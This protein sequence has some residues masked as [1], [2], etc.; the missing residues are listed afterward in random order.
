ME[1]IDIGEDGSGHC[2]QTKSSAEKNAP[3]VFVPAPPYSDSC[4]EVTPFG[5]EGSGAGLVRLNFD[6]VLF[7][8]RKSV[9]R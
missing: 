9:S 3:T 7:L 8:P 4:K 2:K 5:E 1:V 6:L